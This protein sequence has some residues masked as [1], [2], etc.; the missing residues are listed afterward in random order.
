M[1]KVRP[2]KSKTRRGYFT[3]CAG[4]ELLPRAQLTAPSTVGLFNG[5]LALPLQIWLRHRRWNLAQ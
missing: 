4:H 2:D 1:L 5:P 3:G